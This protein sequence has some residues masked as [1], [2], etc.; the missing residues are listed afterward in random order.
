MLSTPFWNKT[1]PGQ[2]GSG[3]PQS[4]SLSD[5]EKSTDLPHSDDCFVVAFPAETTEAFLEGHVPAF[6]YFGGVPP[7]AF[8]RTTPRWRWRGSWATGEAEDEGLL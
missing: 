3:T 2:E 1:R 5:Y 8:F 7:R 4:V 6:A